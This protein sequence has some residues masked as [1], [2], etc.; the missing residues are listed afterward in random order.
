M[1]VMAD[2][3]W[4]II[5]RI[6]IVIRSLIRSHMNVSR[7]GLVVCFDQ[8]DSGPVCGMGEIVPRL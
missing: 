3:D 6:G 1:M 2:R 5:V 4:A 8:S 7:V